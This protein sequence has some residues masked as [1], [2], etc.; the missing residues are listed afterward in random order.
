[1]KFGYLKSNKNLRWPFPTLH[2]FEGV[3]PRSAC[4]KVAVDNKRL[5]LSGDVPST[6]T[7]VCEHC[8][9]GRPN[10]RSKIYGQE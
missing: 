4:G 5:I 10:L 7:T 6:L 8:V 9:Y 1:M 2:I 3:Q